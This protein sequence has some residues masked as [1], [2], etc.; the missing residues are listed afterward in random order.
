MAEF[1]EVLEMLSQL[2]EE[3]QPKKLKE[4]SLEMKKVLESQGE[5]DD[6]KINTCLELVEEFGECIELNSEVRTKVWSLVS[7]LEELNI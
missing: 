4:L 6:I 7:K 5:E 1:T 3:D 2:H